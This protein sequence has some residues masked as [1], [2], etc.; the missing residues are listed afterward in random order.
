MFLLNMSTHEE[1]PEMKV[2]APSGQG[3][4]GRRETLRPVA[5]TRPKARGRRKQEAGTR[6]SGQ[7]PARDQG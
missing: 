3:A 4:G 7:G 1:R 6:P 2:R 5:I